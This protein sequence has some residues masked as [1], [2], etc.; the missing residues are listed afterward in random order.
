MPVCSLGGDIHAFA[1]IFEAASRVLRLKGEIRELERRLRKMP[2][3][4]KLEEEI[5]QLIAQM[6]QNGI[7]VTGFYKEEGN[8]ESLF[9][10]LTGGQEDEN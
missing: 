3:F 1:D 10:Q 6:I 7:I 9:M 5:A 2:D 8:L 4:G